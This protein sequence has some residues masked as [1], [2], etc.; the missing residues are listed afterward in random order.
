MRKELKNFLLVSPLALATL[1]I[2]SLL[3]SNQVLSSTLLFIMG[4]LM[5]CVDWRLKN[6]AFYFAMLVGGPI[7]EAVAIY[8]G[9]WTYT[10]PII[11]GVPIWL[12]FV[13][14]NTGIYVVKLK[15]LIYSF[16]R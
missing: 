13:W 3:G 10:N 11:I 5:L 15:E 8:F 9:A 14:G 16:K 7:A 6:F 2:P 4:L 1:F 12:F